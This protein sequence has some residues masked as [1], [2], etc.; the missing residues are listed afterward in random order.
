MKKQIIRTLNSV[1][2]YLGIPIII[3][4]AL[5]G[6]SK[7]KVYVAGFEGENK[8]CY[9]VDSIKTSLP[10]I[11]GT[12]TSLAI[13]G[14]KIF[15]TGH[16]DSPR[17]KPCYWMN[18]VKTELP[19][20]ES[21]KGFITLGSVNELIVANGKIYALGDIGVFLPDAGGISVPALWVNGINK[22]IND[23]TDLVSATESGGS[24]VNQAAIYNDKIY[25]TISEFDTTMDGTK[26]SFFADGK[27]TPLQGTNITTSAITVANGKVYIAGR[28]KKG[29]YNKACYWI[30]GKRVDLQGGITSRATSIL[31]SGDK[32]YISGFYY[33]NIN[34]ACY[35]VNGRRKDLT[36]GIV[37]GAVDESVKLPISL[38]KG[39]VYIA[40]YY[41]ESDKS[42]SCY[43]IDGAKVDLPEG[44][45]AVAIEV[46]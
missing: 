26:V 30:D 44:T 7:P 13:Y 28:Y 45:K 22:D 15:T 25:A 37:T 46:N 11:E 33:D 19:I 5:S 4:A 27:I 2:T 10:D 23:I 1:L 38:H 6:C 20:Q 8:V 9:W 39:K 24:Y 14:G 36:D 17:K 29:G 42:N 18:G 34:R 31:V 40:G 41:S 32:V 35:W 12:I 3:I 21:T 43:W 16:Y